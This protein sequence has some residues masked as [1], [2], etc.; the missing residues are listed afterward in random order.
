[1]NESSPQ[2]KPS[3]GRRRQNRHM[4]KISANKAYLS[5]SDMPGNAMVEYGE[6]EAP[7]TPQKSA[8]GSPA[9]GHQNASSS[10]RRNN[11]ARP[12]NVTISPDSTPFDR[13]T[14][15][16]T[17]S[18]AKPTSGTAF[19]GAT[20]HASPAPSALPLPSFM[21]KLTP[22]SP[23][24]KSNTHF[25]PEQY[26]PTNQGDQPTPQRPVQGDSAKDSPLD[27]IFR[28]DRA[29]KER[30]RRTSSANSMGPMMGPHSPPSQSSP[31]TGHPTK[32]T[33]LKHIRQTIVQRSG[34]ISPA[35]L[36]GTP[37]Q[38]LGPAFSTPYHERIRASKNTVSSFPSSQS[39]EQDAP[40]QDRSEALK[41]FL[42][43]IG[44]EQSTTSQSK[45]FAPNIEP[46]E[47]SNVNGKAEGH[48]PADIVAMEDNLRR[49]LNIGK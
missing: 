49:L 21:A 13:Q 41:K 29:E 4:A 12:K 20:F 31:E 47:V 8:S 25:G 36:N 39:P 19:A 44:E 35:E 33:S 42:W 1:M 37:R 6:L 10:Q 38:E 30:A 5:E 16:L 15:P 3:S 40:A 2:N 17:A 11:K 22:D 27:M 18:A 23:Q 34:G 26:P 46:S 28:A 14:P 9:P 32:S 24:V 45:P 7:Q 43:G 48:R